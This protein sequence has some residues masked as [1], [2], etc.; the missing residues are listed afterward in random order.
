[1][2]FAE[3]N[4]SSNLDSDQN[5]TITEIDSDSDIEIIDEVALEPSENTSR[6]RDSSE[7]TSND[8]GFGEGEEIQ[9][10]KIQDPKPE[11]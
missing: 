11:M 3:L 5:V 2:E 1:M 8:T 7:T 6:T 10:W 9:G 4:P